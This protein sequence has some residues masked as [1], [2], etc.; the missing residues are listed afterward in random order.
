MTQK[1]RPRVL[2]RKLRLRG[3]VQADVVIIR[4]QPGEQRGLAGLA[5]ARYHDRGK[6][7]ALTIRVQQPFSLPFGTNRLPITCS[8]SV[9][10]LV[11]TL[12]Q[13]GHETLFNRTTSLEGSSVK[14]CPVVFFAA[15][16]LM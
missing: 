12:P 7:A 1:E 9:V 10:S 13:Y 4:K 3:K 11:S 15:C 6:C 16:S 14:V 2:L 8:L 5:G